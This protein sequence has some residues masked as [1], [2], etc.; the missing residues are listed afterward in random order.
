MNVAPRGEIALK[1][2][3]QEFE[4]IYATKIKFSLER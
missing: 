2:I 4:V 1:D 3:Q